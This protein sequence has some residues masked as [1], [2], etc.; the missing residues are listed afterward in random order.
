[1]SLSHPF[2]RLLRILCISLTLSTMAMAEQVTTVTVHYRSAEAVVE[3][4]RDI[5]PSQ[6]VQL[7]GMRNQII[8]RAQSPARVN[9]VKALITQLD[10]R[11]HQFRITMRRQG[12]G[13]QQDQDIGARGT[14]TQRSGNVEITT[15]HNTIS[16]RGQSQQ[17]VT[18]LE[19]NQVLL[20]QGQLRPVRDVFVS[21]EGVATSTR[22]ETIGD[23]LIL[24]P[25]KV[26]NNEV[27]ISVRASH[28][29]DSA[30]H[31]QRLD[32]LELVTQRVVGFG[33]WVELGAVSQT[34][35]DQRQG[36]I[37]YST[38]DSRQQNQFEI[39]VELID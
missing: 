22:Y 28:S 26:G 1:M 10:T 24:T 36:L 17:M 5:Y 13:Y 21:R 27:E 2:I 8:I 29:S 12:E 37:H 14:I 7:S 20:Q 33:E 16:T 38:G 32:Q 31:A 30:T 4:L 9:E 3:R 34:R 11:P 25:R 35:G 39:K 19:D 15:R 18:V 6:E 23:A